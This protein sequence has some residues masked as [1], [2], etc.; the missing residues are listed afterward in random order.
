MNTHAY[1]WRPLKWWMTN[2]TIAEMNNNTMNGV[3]P[4]N[5]KVLLV[6]NQQTI[7]DTLTMLSERGSQVTCKR[8]FQVTF[9]YVDIHDFIFEFFDLYR[10]QLCIWNFGNFFCQRKEDLYKSLLGIYIENIGVASLLHEFWFTLLTSDTKMLLSPFSFWVTPLESLGIKLFR[11]HVH[12]EFLSV[13]WSVHVQ[14]LYTK[15]FFF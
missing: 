3:L 9:T 2:M 1:W 6:S 8:S 7:M 12:E 5:K 15:V 4:E 10:I 11:W 14:R 13:I